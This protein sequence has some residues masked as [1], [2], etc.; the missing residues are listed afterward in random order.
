MR[1][2]EEAMC[3]ALV[4]G[5][6]FSKDNTVVNWTNHPDGSPH[7]ARI[8]LHG[9]QIGFYFYSGEE[10]SWMLLLED[11]GWRTDTTKS[12]LCALLD[13]IAKGERNIVF[14]R[15]EG[16]DGKPKWFYQMGANKYRWDGVHRFLAYE[17][18]GSTT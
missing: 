14:G 3:D 5:R 4:A 12:R 8:L 15:G 16:S 2:I 10:Q 1:K 7:S 11:A 9:N 18:A 13:R 6:S 17:P